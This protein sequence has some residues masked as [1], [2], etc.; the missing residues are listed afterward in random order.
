[1]VKDVDTLCYPDRVFAPDIEHTD[2]LGWAQSADNNEMGSF[3][4]GK[5]KN[6]KWM[7]VF[8]RYLWIDLAYKSPWGCG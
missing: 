3:K 5:R 2:M 6:W 4:L 8:F 7:V 1:M